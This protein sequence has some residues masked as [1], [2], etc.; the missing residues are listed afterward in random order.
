MSFVVRGLSLG[1]C[2]LMFIYLLVVV[3]VF[4]SYCLLVAGCCLSFVSCVVWC[5]LF[6]VAP[7]LLVVGYLC[8]FVVLLDERCLFC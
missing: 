3:L 6:I 8:L 1:S 2:C 4:A 5:W 7:R